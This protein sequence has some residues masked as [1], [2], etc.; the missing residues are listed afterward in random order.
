MFILGPER[1][2]DVVAA[3]E[4]Y[5]HYLK[6]E[7]RRFP[8]NAYELAT[9]DWYFDFR[10]HRCPHDAWIETVA[11]TE[12]AQGEREVERSSAITM[13]L[14]G[15]YHDLG[16][17]FSYPRIYAYRFDTGDCLR[18]HG[19]FRYDEFR[20]SQRGNLLHEIEWA[21]H[22]GTGTWLIEASDVEFT[23]WPLVDSA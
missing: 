11:I 2:K 12:S 7:R 22:Q 15:A 10:D 13:T 4:S 3:F 20:V 17:K 21:T 6:A 5:A 8:Q 16:M 9:S 19:D 18:G 1:D 23:W 14:L